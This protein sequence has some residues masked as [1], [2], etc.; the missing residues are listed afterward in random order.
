MILKQKLRRR[1]LRL[2]AAQ[3]FLAVALLAA[4][5]PAVATAA[6]PASDEYGANFPN[7]SGGK[8]PADAQ[9]VA[10]PDRLPPSTVNRLGR[11]PEG[12]ALI[13]AAT[14]T[15]LGAPA[16]QAPAGNAGL[17]EPASDNGESALTAASNAL[18]TPGALLMLAIAAGS[19]IAAFLIRR[20]NRA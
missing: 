5:T 3:S 6:P 2:G 7:A 18:T 10:R 1:H 16:G 13:A 19:L 4:M 15:E 20:G 12:Q 11:D 8:G 14:A 17:T 9:P